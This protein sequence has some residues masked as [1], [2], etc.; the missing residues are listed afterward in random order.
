MP[1]TS[2][3]EKLGDHQMG[4]RTNTMLVSWNNEAAEALDVS[5]PRN[6]RGGSGIEH[7]QVQN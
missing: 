4:T 1:K 2:G 5:A 6:V 3:C 7:G